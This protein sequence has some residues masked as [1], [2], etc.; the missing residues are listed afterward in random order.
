MRS[1]L[2]VAVIYVCDRLQLINLNG[3]VFDFISLPLFIFFVMDIIELFKKK[4]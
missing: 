2:L 1:V 4:G 3:E